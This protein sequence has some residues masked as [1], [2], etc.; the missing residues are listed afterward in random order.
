MP[1]R[2]VTDA[3]RQEERA[4]IRQAAVK[5]FRAHGIAAISARAVAREAGVSV[6]KI[7]AYFGNLQ[8]LMQS[9]WMTRV[10]DFVG[11]LEALANATPDP[12]TR[13]ERLLEAYAGFALDNPALYKGALMFV[14]PEDLPVPDKDPAGD[15]PLLVLLSAALREGQQAGV[16]RA[17]DVDAMA[18]LLWAGLHGAIALPINIDRFAFRPAT[19]LTGGMIRLLMD[20]ITHPDLEPAD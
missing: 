11:E 2:P 18:Q 15:V 17:G 4:R 5:I 16:V 3:E 1:R 12:V 13:I 14:R 19:D 20:Q 8:D 7:Y 9:L 10:A 6:G